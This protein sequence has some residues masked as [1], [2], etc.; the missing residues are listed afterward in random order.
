MDKKDHPLDAWRQLNDEP[1]PPRVMTAHQCVHAVL[2]YAAERIDRQDAK[3][4]P[5]LAANVQRETEA[6]LH[7]SA[8]STEQYAEDASGGALGNAGIFVEAVLRG[9][10]TGEGRT[11]VAADVGAALP[12]ATALLDK[13]AVVLAGLT[14]TVDEAPVAAATPGDSVAADMTA[15]MHAV[16][17]RIAILTTALRAAMP[18][19]LA[20]LDEQ[21]RSP[22]HTAYLVLAGITDQ[23]NQRNV[24]VNEGSFE[25][26]RM[27]MDEAA[28]GASDAA[29]PETVLWVSR[30]MRCLCGDPDASAAQAHPNVVRAGLQFLERHL[31]GATASERLRAGERARVS[32]EYLDATRHGVSI[33]LA[34]FDRFTPEPAPEGPAP[35][36]PPRLPTRRRR[37]RRE[38]RRGK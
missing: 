14:V 17:G 30:L 8:L 18:D 26:M 5:D 28:N 9:L 25:R 23:L 29:N 22:Q 36:A 2:D 19:A 7:A 37:S 32:A 27:F 3:L 10:V 6:I 1:V 35:P 33:L 13:C 11:D 4:G 21:V 12:L 16:A 24:P 38:R 20:A 31:A 15:T 34:P